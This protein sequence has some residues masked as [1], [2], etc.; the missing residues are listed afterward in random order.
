VHHYHSQSHKVNKVMSPTSI[1]F[2]TSFRRNVAS[3]VTTSDEED[4]HA[5]DTDDSETTDIEN[6]QDG[7]TF[8]RTVNK[9]RRGTSRSKSKKTQK[10]DAK[11]R[12]EPEAVAITTTAATAT[13]TTKS[14][15]IHRKGM[16]RREFQR[17]YL[18]F[19][20]GNRVGKNKS[21]TSGTVAS[22]WSPPPSPSSSSSSYSSE[23]Y[24]SGGA[25]YGSQVV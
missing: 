6:N 7:V 11:D 9:D 25:R 24:S 2:A 12:H 16:V 4:V 10:P 19:R 17:R 22:D 1:R 15:N 21:E 14:P 3:P 8:K 20:R 23:S 18:W 5:S 13:M